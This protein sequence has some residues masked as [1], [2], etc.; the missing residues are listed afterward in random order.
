MTQ[1]EFE[2]KLIDKSKQEVINIK[3][4]KE[5]I[6]E[7]LPKYIN[8]VEI[9]KALYNGN[10]TNLNNAIKQLKFDFLENQNK[11]T[12]NKVKQKNINDYLDWLK[13]LNQDENNIETI[14]KILN[15]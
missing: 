6:K 14:I 1:K 13:K 4:R 3:D 9:T 10:T 5:K 2:H 7:L 8:C 11:K 12:S 15:N